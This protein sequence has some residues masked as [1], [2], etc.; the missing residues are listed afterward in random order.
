MSVADQYLF[1]GWVKG[2]MIPGFAAWPRV[3][4]DESKAFRFVT[5][6]ERAVDSGG[7][8]IRSRS[9]R[10]SLCTRSVYVLAQRAM[11]H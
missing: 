5:F 11:G 10:A 6:L 9:I 4:A 8:D 7:P 1:R 2:H 3:S